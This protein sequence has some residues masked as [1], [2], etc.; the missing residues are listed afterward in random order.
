MVIVLLGL[1]L[2]VPINTTSRLMAILVV[3]LYAVVGAAVYLFILHKTKSINNIFG[4]E[5]INELLSRKKKT[6]NIK[7]KKVVKNKIQKKR[8]VN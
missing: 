2:V 1:K 4:E 3:A 8:K 7:P 5:K 6:K